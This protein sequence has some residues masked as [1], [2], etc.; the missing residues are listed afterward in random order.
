MPGCE[1][2]RGIPGKPFRVMTMSKARR[3]D[4][5]KLAD[6]ERVRILREEILGREAVRLYPLGEKDAEHEL[7]RFSEELWKSRKMEGYF[8]R[9]HLVNL[10]GHL[11]EAEHGFTTLQNG[12]ILE[13]ISIPALPEGAM[14]FQIFFV[15]DPRDNADLGKLIGYSIYSLETG[16]AP[17][18]RAEAVRL[19]FDIFPDYREGRYRKV[20]FT[21]HEIYNVSRRILMRFKPARF[22]VDARTQIIQTRTGNPFKRVVY[23]VKRGYYPPDQKPLADA[24]LAR[25]VQGKATGRKTLAA[26]MQKAQALFWVFPAVPPSQ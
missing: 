25:L 4:A 5:S 17:F 19:A 12:G 15:F 2:S 10:R 6:Q 8:D 3:T 14:G 7:A 24:C 9:G 11:G 16:Q 18:G 20:P 21:N 23:Y 13:V 1:L 22:V 26:L